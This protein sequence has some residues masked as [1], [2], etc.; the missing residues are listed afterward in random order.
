MEAASEIIGKSLKL[1]VKYDSVTYTAYR[2]HDTK[3]INFC[4]LAVNDSILHVLLENFDIDIYDFYVC[5]VLH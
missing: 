4:D 5:G 1:Y 3:C 2:T